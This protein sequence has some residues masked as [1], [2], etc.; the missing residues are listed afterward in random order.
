VKEVATRVRGGGGGGSTCWVGGVG[1]GIVVGVGWGEGLVVGVRLELHTAAA[2]AHPPTPPPTHPPT[3]PT[4]KIMSKYNEGGETRVGWLDK[5]IEHPHRIAL[6]VRVEVVA[7][8]RGELEE[9][10]GRSSAGRWG[11]KVRGVCVCVCV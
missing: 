8:V 9:E 6:S 3:H 7:A 11:V 1:V 5:G 4:L 2:Q 10:V